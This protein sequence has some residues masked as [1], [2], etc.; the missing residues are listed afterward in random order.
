MPLNGPINTSE[1]QVFSYRQSGASYLLN[2]LL[3]LDICIYGGQFNSFWTVHDNGIY[4]LN[5]DRRIPYGA[6]FPRL[7]T[8]KEFRF[9]PSVSCHWR[10]HDFPNISEFDKPTILMIRDLRDV[11][12]SCAAHID[13]NVNIIKFLQSSRP[14]EIDN[15][16]SLYPVEEWSLYYGIISKLIPPEKLCLVRFEDIKKN[17]YQEVTRILQFLGLNIEPTLIMTAIENSSHDNIKKVT[18]GTTFNEATLEFLSKGGHI[19]SWK[20]IIAD[21]EKVV[22]H[23]LPNY[24]LQ[25]FGYNSDSSED[26][27]HTPINGLNIGTG[28]NE[29][30]NFLETEKF[31]IQKSKNIDDNIQQI[32]TIGKSLACCMWTRDLYGE[33]AVHHPDNVLRGYGEDAVHHPTAL[34][35]LRIFLQLSQYMLDRPLILI[36]AARGLIYGR[37]FEAGRGLLQYVLSQEDIN[38]C[39]LVEAGQYCLASLKDKKLAMNFFAKAASCVDIEDYLWS[40]TVQNYLKTY[41][42]CTGE[43]TEDSAQQIQL[44]KGWFDVVDYKNNQLIVAGWMLLPGME[45]D[46]FKVY[47]FNQYICDTPVYTRKDVSRAFP[48]IKNAGYSGFSVSIKIDDKKIAERDF[49]LICV[50]GMS[51]GKKVAKMESF[52]CDAYSSRGVALSSFSSLTELIVERSLA[53]S[54]LAERDGRIASLNQSVTERDGRIASLHQAVVERD[55]RIT[56]LHQAVTK[57]DEQNASLNKAVTERDGQNASLNKAVTERDLVLSS[58]T[59]ELG[60]INTSLSWKL[61]MPLRFADSLLRGYWTA[62]RKHLSRSKGG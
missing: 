50:I 60:R 10:F 30:F 1:I 34:K 41:N 2:I 54:S 7:Q 36:A 19:G 14:I 11:M 17:P 8:G 3:E 37:N 4:E 45:F 58:L 56:S 48:V 35:T 39:E 28:L 13:P 21:K 43:I 44:A 16:F 25:S 9:R 32:I 49:L 62:I 53:L 27:D 20:N 46:L 40:V 26:A 47:I 38:F 52:F 23:G 15:F 24:I 22:F 59:D 18:A 5:E 57:R 61:T 12:V 29:N 55:G 51:Y 42:I 31:L 33:D 6:W